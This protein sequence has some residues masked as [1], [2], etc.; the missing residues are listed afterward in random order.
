MGTIRN[1]SQSDITVHTEAGE[2]KFPA[3]KVSGELATERIAAIEESGAVYFAAGELVTKGSD[4]SE[5][6]TA[7]AA[8]D[9]EA[10]AKADAEATAK[11]AKKK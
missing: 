6:A 11:A 9:A 1:T 5:E 7:K 4:D 10:K 2:F 3:G 8:A